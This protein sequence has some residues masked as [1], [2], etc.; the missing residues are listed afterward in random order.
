MNEH[1]TEHVNSISV[2]SQPHTV[3]VCEDDLLSRGGETKV[4]P[5]HTD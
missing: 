2:M 3:H 4:M 5:I 1:V